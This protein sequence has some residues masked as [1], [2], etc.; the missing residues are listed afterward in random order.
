MSRYLH[1]SDYIVVIQ[2]SQLAQIVQ[3][4][5]NKLLKAE[6]L[7]QDEISSYLTQR[8]DMQ[9]E[10]TNTAPWNSS[11]SYQPNQRVI[12]DYDDFSSVDVYNS[13]DCAILN[14][15]GIC[16]TGVT[17]SATFSGPYNPSLWSDMG[18]QYTLYYASYPAPLFNYLNYYNIGDEVYWKGYSWV[19]ATTTNIPSMTQVNQYMNVSNIPPNNV[20]P[21]S[22]AN[23]NYAYWTKGATFSMPLGTLPTNKSYWTEGDNRC[24][25]LLQWYMDIV[26]YNCHKTIAP[27]NVP[28]QKV[29][30]YKIAIDYLIKIGSGD[31]TLN[32]LVRQP[33]QGRMFRWG[34]STQNPSQW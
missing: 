33:I 23:S 19:C 6:R 10:F 4:D 29:T 26:I 5:Q 30:A 21:D 3:H 16:L 32:A 27:R 25:Q 9:Y 14:G 15:V 13:G 24:Q 34:G 11:T 20:F 1:N 7:A 22:S 17:G 2:D 31:Y 18:D 8:W 28:E 12:I